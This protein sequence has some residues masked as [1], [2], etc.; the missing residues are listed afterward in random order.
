MNKNLIL[1]CLLFAFVFVDSALASCKEPTKP[2]CASS[3]SVYSNKEA[4]N[5]C[6]VEV[7]SFY[8]SAVSYIDC[9]KKDLQS[10]AEQVQQKVDEISYEANSTIM[11]FN[12]KSGMEEDC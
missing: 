11:E 8:E 7:E 1:V 5:V 3:D 2:V 10:K 12:C 6:K 9:L 4:Y